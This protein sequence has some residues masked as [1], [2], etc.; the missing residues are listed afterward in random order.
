MADKSIV[1]LKVDTELW[2]QAKAKAAIAGKTL[3][4]YVTEAIREKKKKGVK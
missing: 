2:R 1:Y 4:D 3:Q